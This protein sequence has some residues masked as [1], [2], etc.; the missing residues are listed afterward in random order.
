MWSILKVIGYF[1]YFF[2]NRSIYYIYYYCVCTDGNNI[3]RKKTHLSSTSKKK[4]K[5][6]RIRALFMRHRNNSKMVNIKHFF[7]GRVCI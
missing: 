2:L 1:C 7:F 5:L 6:N 4:M 3:E